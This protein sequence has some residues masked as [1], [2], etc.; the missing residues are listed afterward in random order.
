MQAGEIIAK[1]YRIERL[2]GSGGTAEVYD[3]T[4]EL[5]GDRLALKR[6]N[7][8]EAAGDYS[9]VMFARE[10]N[11]LAQL[12]HPLIIRAFD[13]VV[14]GKIPY[15]T[16]ELPSGE[17]LIK[18]APLGWRDA[19]HLLRDFAPALGIVHSRPLV[20]RVVTTRNV[21]RVADGHA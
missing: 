17:N 1:R 18:L 21:C 10:Y 6:L 13:Y 14:V 3:D 20:H 2:V 5:S 15:Y 16:M 7:S 12:L 11:E 19:C 4:D 8:E 9:A